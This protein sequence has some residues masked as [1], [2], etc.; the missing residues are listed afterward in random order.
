MKNT[1][2]IL[3]QHY[4]IK[5]GPLKILVVLLQVCCFIK[6]NFKKILRADWF[7]CPK[8]YGNFTLCFRLHRKE[9][10][11]G[12][13]ELCLLRFKLYIIHIYILCVKKLNIISYAI[14]DVCHEFPIGWPFF[15]GHKHPKKIW[16]YVMLKWNFNDRNG[17]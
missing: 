3:H 13:F 2:L 7:F 9:I 6:L 5:S 12:L 4:Q 8:I 15:S 14:A 11:F 17:L 1:T 16:C 10:T